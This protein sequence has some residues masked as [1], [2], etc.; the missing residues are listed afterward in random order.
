MGP[1]IHL[2]AVLAL[3]VPGLLRAAPGSDSHLGALSAEAEQGE[4]KA[5]TE[6]AIK[7]EYAEGVPQD[8]QK[9]RR[10]FCEA[11]KHGYPEAQFQLGWL[12]ANGR[13]V[14]HD[15]G[16]AAALFMLA[17]KQGHEYAATMLHYVAAGRNTQLPRCL[18]PEPTAERGLQDSEAAASTRDRIKDLVYRLA[19]QYGVD[20]KLALAVI[21][22]E[23]GFNGSAVSP[24]NAQGLMQLIPQ[25]AERFRVKG[26][27]DPVQNVRG[28]LAYLR[29]LLAYFR[30]NVMLVLAAYNAGERAVDKYR[31]MPPYAETRDY[32]RKITRVYKKTSVPFEAAVVEPS[33]I[34]RDGNFPQR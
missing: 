25:T 18:L 6:L 8:L 13:G 26:V 12:Y 34:V 15:D 33:P 16:V 31:G 2:F 7:Y 9:A 29:W 11:A 10:L 17:A 5:Q 21:A 27:F 28:G 32:V 4:Q 23:S 22:V 20:P 24:K 19:P 30:G 3:L 14:A 1:S